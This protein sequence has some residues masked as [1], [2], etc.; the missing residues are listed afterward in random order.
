M[1]V[2]FFFPILVMCPYI[3]TTVLGGTQVAADPGSHLTLKL[4][5]PLQNL[6]GPGADVFQRQLLSCATEESRCS[7]VHVCTFHSRHV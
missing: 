3:P 5:G 2:H 7:G 6:A 4:A 1:I